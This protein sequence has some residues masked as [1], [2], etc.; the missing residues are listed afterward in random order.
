MAELVQHDEASSSSL[1]SSSTSPW[2][3][4]PLPLYTKFP[5]PSIPELQDL[6]PPVP[7]PSTQ[8]S[9]I[10]PPDTFWYL[11]S[12]TSILSSSY[13]TL[14]KI[15]VSHLSTLPSHTP[16]SI[17]QSDPQTSA[18]LLLLKSRLKTIITHLQNL[19]TQLNYSGCIII[20]PPLSSMSSHT[21]SCVSHIEF[22]NEYKLLRG[23][24][25]SFFNGKSL[26]LRKIKKYLR[27]KKCRLPI[28][29][30]LPSLPEFVITLSYGLTFSYSL[31]SE[32]LEVKG[33]EGVVMDARNVLHGVEVVEGKEGECRVGVVAWRGK[34]GREEV[35]E[36]DLGVGGIFGG[37]SDSD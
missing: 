7:P 4:T 22:E 25:M 16:Q 8:S 21:D 6:L 3:P 36:V 9:K 27:S 33:N 23:G 17:D 26:D 14:L 28:N 29:Y 2:T 31:D 18:F 1:E 15:Y 5:I 37:D 11:P 32:N 20:Y 10:F 34:G 30:Y 12:V 13:E 19:S 24:D 35:E